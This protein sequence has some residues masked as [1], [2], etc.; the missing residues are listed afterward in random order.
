MIRIKA[1]LPLIMATLVLCT[2]TGP[3]DAASSTISAVVPWQ[4]QGQ[5]FPVGTDKLRFLGY[6][7]GIMY[8]ETAEG[9]MNEAFVRCP[10][11]QDIDATDGT[12]S[13]SGNCVI[14]ASTTDSVFAELTCEGIAGLCSGEFK[15]TG[16]TGRFEGISGS[17]KMTVRSPVH[18][19]AA[20]LS[21][22]TVVHLAA[23]ILQ[24]PELKYSLP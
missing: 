4:G 23:G 11:V 10:I 13:A 2:W 22:G 9:D 1:V 17:G 3:T 14:V 12:T 7:E 19:L 24:I 20:D 5:I 15:L 6:L 8:V 21:E 16:G 18:V